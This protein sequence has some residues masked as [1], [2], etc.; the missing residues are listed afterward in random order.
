MTKLFLPVATTAMITEKLPFSYFHGN[1]CQGSEFLH[2]NNAAYQFK[3]SLKKWNQTDKEPSRKV[4]I[5]VHIYFPIVMKKTAATGS[6][7]IKS[8]FYGF[9]KN[10]FQIRELI[11]LIFLT[12][13]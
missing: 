8:Y 6:N 7:H 2:K 5:K 3:L 4:A 10:I 1:H 13:I 12:L 11:L 9:L